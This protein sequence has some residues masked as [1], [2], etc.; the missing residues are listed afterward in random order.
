MNSKTIKRT[1]A[2]LSAL[3]MAVSMTACAGGNSQ[4]SEGGTTAAQT[5]ETTAPATVAINTATLSQ[6]EEAAVD[7]AS[8]MLRDVE[9]E[10]KEIKWLCHWDL[11]P[12]S[13]G[14]SIPVP[15]SLFQSKYDGEITWYPTTWNT[16]YSDLSTYVLGGEGIDFFQRDESS[17][18]KG[19]VSGMFS[20]IDDYIDIDSDLYDGV[21]PGMDL[22]SFKG[23][24]Y[25]F[26]ND[27]TADAAVIYSAKTID[28][29]GYDDPWE[30]YQ[31]GKW[32][33]DTFTKML[34]DFC[35]PEAEQYGLD[36]WW[37]EKPLYLSAGTPAVS[38]VDGLL[39]VNL[40]DGNLE[41]AQNW[42]Y[43][44]W[45]K[46]LVFDKSL[47]DWSIQTHFMGEG[48]EL[49]FICGTWTL[50]AD[51]ST[52][53][54]GIA[55]EDARW[56]PIPCPADAEE[57]YQPA[58]AGGYCLCKGASNPLGVALYVE[59]ELVAGLDE[60]TKAV[61]R[62]KQKDDYQ[63]SDILIEQL[64]EIN[65]QAKEHPIV[66]MADGVSSDLSSLLTYADTEGIK[67]SMH[68]TDWATTRDTMNDTV[69]T[70]VDEFNAELS[71]VE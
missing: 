61:N 53:E 9:L 45:S 33:W 49:F 64:E 37:S 57:I 12:D 66:E 27:V 29:N 28:E 71:A 16:R 60:E 1:L 52:W 38:S 63:W 46:G 13:T 67:A 30:L 8:S 59:C 7:S 20:P 26:V 47:F 2:G 55:P 43:S 19:I 56:V 48:K 36:G 62:Q 54:C 31:E 25:A 65:K 44:L 24:H 68:G 18:P 5:A 6:E 32:N 15:L 21:R 51:P 40:R 11:N 23:K 34:E 42:M 17:L 10:D 70:M 35:D 50:M 22:Y 58:T 69:V 41:K 39:Q 14:K 4:G 3:T